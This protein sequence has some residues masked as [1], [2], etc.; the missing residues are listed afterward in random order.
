M[1][2]STLQLAL[3][4][5]TN[6]N[7]VYAYITGL[8]VDKNEALVLIESDGVTPYYPASPSS[9]G[10]PLATNCAIP[11]G[12][13]GSTTN[14]TIPRIAG[15]RV[16]FSVNG[17]LTFLINPGP[18]LVE[19]TVANPNDPNINTQWDFCEFTFNQYELYA[20]ITYVDFVSVP[21]GMTLLNA[22]NQTQHVSGL[23]SNGLQTVASGLEAQDSSDHAGWSQLIVN[24]PSGL[25]RILSPNMGI[26]NNS[27]LFNGY[28][29]PY[30]NQVYTMYQN[31]TLTVDTQDTW[32][33]VTGKVSNNELTFSGAGSFAMPSTANIFSNSS[34]PFATTTTEMGDIGARLA[35]AFNRS[36]LLIDS[37][38][39]DGEN[40]ANYYKNAITNH[41]ARIL[42]Q[43]NLD[44]RGYAFPYDDVA[45]SGGA[46][47]SGYFS[48]GNPTL[49]TIAV[50]GGN[51]YA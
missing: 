43:T 4:N 32:G 3:Q 16:W 39:P 15:G 6:S 44:G 42:H 30:V 37:D 12:A 45:P 36:T 18:G 1:T 10:Q 34:G 13:P 46:D 5:Q 49:W 24:G 9:T 17:T 11:L 51:A 41:Y 26:T 19:P 21:I 33:I 22:S 28:Y 29:D 7:T 31:Q 23:P 8:A 35:A 14:V 20:N 2:N 38:Q 27:S 25:L 48:D 50:G 47:Q 40:P